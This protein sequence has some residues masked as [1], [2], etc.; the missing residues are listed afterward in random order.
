[1]IAAELFR[2]IYFFLFY[3]ALALVLLRGKA[4]HWEWGPLELSFST[5]RNILFALLA[6]GAALWLWQRPRA[7][8]RTPLDGVFLVWLPVL[9]LSVVFSRHPGESLNS[10]VTLACYAGFFYLF[11]ATIR[12]PARLRGWFYLWLGIASLVCL[13]DLAYFLYVVSVSPVVPIV[14]DYPFWPGK[15]MLG[16]FAALNI[17][18]AFGLLCSRASLRRWEKC[19]VAAALLLSG[20]V[21]AI[22]FSRTAWVSCAA[23]LLAL[24][25]LRPKIFV[26]LILAGILA[27]AL[28]APYGLKGRIRSMGNF[29]EANVKER[30]LIWKSA[31][32]MLRDAPATGVGLGSFYTEYVGTY[33]LKGTKLK[34][35]GEHAHNLYLHV[36]AEMGIPGLLTLLMMFAFML[37]F[38]W[39]KYRDEADPFQKGLRLGAFLSLIAFIAYSLTDST[40]NGRFSD[41]S[42]FHVNLF[43][44]MLA[45]MLVRE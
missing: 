16:L 27:T 17:A 22:T 41:Y 29:K 44:I 32:N 45:A 39:G 24:A 9:A 23:V 7:R 4:L 13:I 2:K 1:M 18:V 34:W 20:A 26:P 5:A 6:F 37:R 36:A 43:A 8:L 31:T 12:D 11:A 25:F 14:E 30:L 35:A 15:N 21:L 28:F 19:A 10:L 33:K 40:F 42:M 3:A 38:G